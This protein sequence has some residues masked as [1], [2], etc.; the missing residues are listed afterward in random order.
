MLHTIIALAGADQAE[1]RQV[2]RLGPRRRRGR[3]HQGA[4]RLRPGADL[5]RSTTTCSRTPARSV[6][7]R[8]APR[9]PS[10]RSAY[11]A[12]RAANPERAALLDRLA[13]RQLPDGLDDGAA[14]VRRRRQGRRDPR[15]VRQ[16]PHRA[17]RR[18]ARAVGRLGRPRR[19]AT[20]RPWRAS[21]RFIPTEHADQGVDGRPLRPH[22]A[23]RHPRA[24]HGRRSSTASRCTG[25]T[26]ALRRHLPG[27]Q[28]LHAPG[29][30]AGRADAAAG[31]LRLDARLDRS[32]RGRPD[33]PADRAPGRAARHPGPRRR[34]PGR[35]QRDRGRL[36]H[37]PR[38]HRPA[39]RPRPDPPE[40]AGPR[41]RH[42]GYASAE[43]R[44]QGRLRPRR[45]PSGGTP[46]VILDRAPAPR[47]S[48]PSRRARPLAGQGVADPR[49]VDA[50]PR[51]VRRAGPARTATQVLPP[52]VRARVS[53]R[54]R[55]RP[56]AGATSSATP[57][58]SSRIEHFGASA[59]YQTLY[60]EFGI[61]AEA[62]AVAAAR[63]ASPARRRSPADLSQ[64]RRKHP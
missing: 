2:A 49:R 60:R 63:R 4:A 42:D 56:W 13:A 34:P 28:R 47:C 43:R 41:P 31:H 23:L 38:A 44:R 27:L 10:G 3:R 17:R 30:P 50:V 52:A 20:T 55:R 58:G 5:R 8:P 45:R 62:V 7:A 36:A 35:R 21:R 15:R 6:D 1:H 11:D 33:P 9:T 16:G 39:R 12:W 14:G 40:P 37:D 18:A 32:R 64:Q 46:D 25:C 59:D 48:S 26:R 22:A 24:R 57:A 29:G 53:R 51:V 54:G 61:T 19:V